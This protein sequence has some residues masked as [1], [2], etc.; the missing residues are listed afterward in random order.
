MKICLVSVFCSIANGM[1]RHASLL[2]TPFKC[3]NAR[4]PMLLTDTL[5]LC[6]NVFVADPL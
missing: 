6:H 3:S 4:C 2:Q 1:S 5:N